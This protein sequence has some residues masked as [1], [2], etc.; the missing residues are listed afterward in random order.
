[1]RWSKILATYK[2]QTTKLM[3]MAT[4]SQRLLCSRAPLIHLFWEGEHV[5]IYCA[6]L[7]FD[8]WIFFFSL[9]QQQS[10]EIYHMQKSCS[11]HL[12]MKAFAYLAP[13]EAGMALTE[14]CCPGRECRRPPG[15]HY[16]DGCDAADPRR[17][18]PPT[19][20]THPGLMAKEK[21]EQRDWKCLEQYWKKYH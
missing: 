7:H 18:S 2:D 6:W 16:S 10:A 19:R 1:M 14:W 20:S 3:S 13:H 15:P 5:S 17:H 21:S 9:Y 8:D 11:S 12:L 4:F